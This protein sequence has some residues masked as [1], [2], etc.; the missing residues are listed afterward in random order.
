MKGKSRSAGFDVYLEMGRKRVFAGVLEWP[1]WCRSGRTDEEALQALTDYGPR[2]VR[3]LGRAGEGL[4]PPE[5]PAGLC[6]AERLAGDA[7][8]DFGVPGGIP[9]FDRRPIDRDE[10]E[11]LVRLLRACWRAFDGSARAAV[12]VE[13]RKGPRG[14]GRDLDKMVNHVL[15]A[16]QAYLR[17]VG[18]R[19]RA[20]TTPDP[21]AE[22]KAVRAQVIQAL[23]DRVVGKPPA[24]SRRTSPLWPPRYAVRR[25]A[26]HALD[27]AWEIQDRAS[28]ID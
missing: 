16:D 8:T 25:S 21:S 1:G 28:P 20:P 27:H 5:E 9:S 17:Q 14:G 24:P 10:Q 4:K 23:R 18:G 26:W 7:T 15:E 2:Y 22:M 13:L 6:V 3:V 11:R 12:G 19:Y